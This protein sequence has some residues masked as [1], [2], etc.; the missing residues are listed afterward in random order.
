MCRDFF[1]PL[2]IFN[3][4]AFCPTADQITY[5]NSSL[6]H[7]SFIDHFFVSDSVRHLIQS[8]V[9]ADS[10]ANLSDHR[11]LVCHFWFDNLAA[12]SYT[13]AKGQEANTVLPAWRWDKADTSYYYEATRLW[14]KSHLQETVLIV[15]WV[16]L[17][18]SI[19]ILSTHIITALLMLCT[20]Q[21]STLSHV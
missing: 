18:L 5:Y 20:R 3:C 4:D 19:D 7:S 12:N 9:T 6:G 10:G 17:T 11:A 14:H 13:S 15:L 1:D 8:M 16:V 2:R 21:L